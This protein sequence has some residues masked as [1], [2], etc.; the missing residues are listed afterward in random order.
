MNKMGV[1]VD[2]QV[3]YVGKIYNMNIIKGWSL[4]FVFGVLVF[5]QLL[6][7]LKIKHNITFVDVK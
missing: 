4:W 3:Y 5:M 6:K 2:I 1:E 7:V